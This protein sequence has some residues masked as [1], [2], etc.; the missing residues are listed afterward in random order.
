MRRRSARRAAR[1]AEG[2]PA[3]VIINQ[4]FA[5]KYFPDGNPLGRWVGLGGAQSPWHEVV[6]IVRDSK[7]RTLGELPTPFVYQPVAQQHETGMTLL[8]R[9]KS[10]PRNMLGHLRRALLELE[11]NLPLSDVQLLGA[12][13]ASSLF[14]ARM[15]ARLPTLFAMLAAL[16]AAIGLYG[17]ISFAVSRRTRELGIRIA[18]GARNRDL[19][20]LIIG[21]GLVMVGIGIAIGWI[22]SALVTRLVSGFL[23]VNATDPP[24]FAAAAAVLGLVMLGATYVPTRRAS[25]C[26]PLEALRS[27]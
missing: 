26:N 13:V 9:T 7:Y 5:A 12:L 4:S 17:V 19:M 16:L 11:P 15:A 3:V 24:T 25:N 8:V 6:G 23:Y 14:P 2:A 10:E 18:L 20:T 1:A 22:A 27:E 21:E